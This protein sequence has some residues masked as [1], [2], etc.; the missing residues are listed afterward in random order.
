MSAT[1]GNS[2]GSRGGRGG[3]GKAHAPLPRQVLYPDEP[4]API[5][6]SGK[7]IQPR[8]DDQ[9]TIRAHNDGAILLKS[10]ENGFYFKKGQST[11]TMEHL[12]DSL[13]N[14]RDAT[15]N[16]EACLVHADKAIETNN[17]LCQQ[18][19]DT[20]FEDKVNNLKERYREMSQANSLPSRASNDDR[21]RR[22]QKLLDDFAEIFQLTQNA[23]VHTLH[24]ELDEIKASNTQLRAQ[25]MAIKD[26]IG[27]CVRKEMSGPAMNPAYEDEASR[28]AE[29][30]DRFSQV[31]ANVQERSDLQESVKS[32][33][34]EKATLKAQLAIAS[35]PQ[36]I[37]APKQTDSSLQRKLREA[38]QEAKWLDHE[39][40]KA[41]D[42]I[43]TLENNLCEARDELRKSRRDLLKCRLQEAKERYSEAQVANAQH[44]A[45]QASRREDDAFGRELAALQ[46]E[47]TAT[48][49]R[50]DAIKAKNDAVQERKEAIQERKEAIQE[51]N[52]AVKDK[53]KAMREKDKAIKEKDDAAK[54]AGASVAEREN[55]LHE[56][57]KKL[58][59]GQ[60]GTLITINALTSQLEQKTKEAN[61]QTAEIVKQS[62]EASRLR[63]TIR[64]WHLQIRSLESQ[65][66]F[67][68]KGKR[69]L[70]DDNKLQKDIIDTNDKLSNIQQKVSDRRQQDLKS[71]TEK[72]FDAQ[73]LLEQRLE[74][75]QNDNKRLHEIIEEQTSAKRRRLPSYSQPGFNGEELDQDFDNDNY[76]GGEEDAPSDYPSSPPPSPSQASASSFHAP[77]ASSTP[78][79]P[80]PPHRS[81]PASPLPPSPSPVHA[82]PPPLKAVQDLSL[83]KVQVPGQALLS[84]ADLSPAV[85][86]QLSTDIIANPRGDDWYTH[87]ANPRVKPTSCVFLPPKKSGEFHRT[88]TGVA[89]RYCTDQGH[90]CIRKD[91]N[92]IA[93]LPRCSSDRAGHTIDAVE[94]WKTGKNEV[95][96][97]RIGNEYNKRKSRGPRA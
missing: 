36:V 30:I 24:A 86:Q 67:S 11:T 94:F 4:D 52:Q 59:E 16:Y 55:A 93:L 39:L 6:K 26:A 90:F 61:E 33:E 37:Q 18:A 8:A 56:R 68:E 63:A 23:Q 97:S 88:E 81:S 12:G 40:E 57:E 17:L 10:Y 89:C 21:I 48:R 19:A 7:R 83:L 47:G 32:L 60:D 46:R 80:S 85:Q 76:A 14:A 58:A 45:H 3:M 38:L 2:R 74:G 73:T 64:H 70:G 62:A 15:A 54:L 75:L 22:Q 53:D 91:G 87:R 96:R 31:A 44:A 25:A 20:R 9:S 78:P 5:M 51:R 34:A 43:G 65:L 72:L 1:S 42:T 27:Q 29:L 28:L 92:N 82:P 95:P 35:E 79:P 84:F 49:E 13:Q 77:P 41:N 50:D 66:E 69:L 71:A